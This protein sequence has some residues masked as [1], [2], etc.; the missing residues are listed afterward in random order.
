LHA[1]GFDA[2]MTALL[3]GFGVTLAAL[4]RE[5]SRGLSQEIRERHLDHQWNQAFTLGP[6]VALIAGPKR[7]RT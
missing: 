7:G 4:P 3:I 2:T 5:E 6:R 1:V